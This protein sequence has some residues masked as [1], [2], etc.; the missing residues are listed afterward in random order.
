ML[1]IERISPG[2]IGRK[3]K[4]RI[5]SVGDRDHAIIAVIEGLKPAACVLRFLKGSHLQPQEYTLALSVMSEIDAAE[6]G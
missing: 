1:S 2:D 4:Y 5:I 6:R 3:S